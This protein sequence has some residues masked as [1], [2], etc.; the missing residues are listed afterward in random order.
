MGLRSKILLLLFSVLLSIAPLSAQLVA[1]FDP[2]NFSGN[3]SNSGCSP[4]IVF[5]SDSST[6]NGSPV[7]YR[8]IANGDPFNS[9]QWF[10]GLGLGT[11]STLYRPS[12]VYTNAGTYTARLIVTNDGINYDT[13]T[14]QITVF[15]QPVVGFYANV[16]SGCNPLTV[17]LCDTSSGS[18]GWVWDDGIGNL[19][20]DSCIVVTYNIG[21]NGQN[22]FSVTLIAE[23]QYGC[24]RSLTKNNYICIDRPPQ[25]NFGADQTVLC[26]S[27]FTV[28]F[29]DSSMSTNGLSYNWNFGAGQGGS[30]Q[31]NPSHTY[32]DTT[33]SYTVQ[34]TVTDSA[35]GT[36]STRSR[37]SYIRTSNVSA[38]FTAS[39]DTICAGESVSF[40]SNIIGTYTGVRWDFGPPGATSTQLNPTRVYNTP[41]L[42][43]V[44]LTVNGSYGC[45]HDTT[46]PDMIYVRPLPT[47][48][49]NG[50][51]TSSCQ[52]PFDVTFTPVTGP[53]VVSWQWYFQHPNPNIT[54]S[55]FS[56]TYT[57]NN[58]G[59]YNVRLVVTDIYGCTNT[60][61]KNN[62]IQI[63]PTTVDFSMDTSE[64]CAPL[65]VD[66]TDNSSSFEP[67]ISWSWD[68][69]DGMTSAIRNT[70]HTYNNVGVYSACLTI[71]TQSG[72]V[73]TR[74]YDVRVGSSATAAFT[75]STLSTCVDVPVSFVNNSS[76]QIDEYDW[77]FG[78]GSSGSSSNTPQPYPYETAG[79]YTVELTVGYNGC[80]S[81]TS[82]D[83]E[84]I[85]P[86]ADFTYQ[87]NCQTRGNLEF[88]NTSQGGDLFEWDFGDGSPTVN[89]ENP[90]HVYA[91]TGS[92]DVTLTVT[93]TTNG[94]V[95]EQTETLVVSVLNADFT[96]S[97]TSGCAP[98]RIFF[99][100]TST[101][102]QISYRWNFGDPGSGT[103]G[104]LLAN[105]EH[106]YSNPG[107]YTVR[108]IVTD[109]YGC[110]DTM[111]RPQYITISDIVADFTASPLTG[112]IEAATGQSPTV[113][114]TDLSVN[115]GNGPVTW[116]WNF[117]DLNTSTV[118]N[119]SHNYNTAG[120]YDIKLRVRNGDGCVDSMV[121]PQYI[122][123]NQP[124]ANFSIPFNLFCIGQPINFLNTTAGG[125][126]IYHWDFGV[127]GIN[128]DTSRQRDP[129]YAYNDTGFYDVGLWVTDLFGCKDSLIIP[130]AIRI[131]IPDLAFTADDTFR[132][133]PPHIVNFTNFASFDTAQVD[134]VLWNFG[135]N[136]FS[137]VFNPSHIYNRAGQF[138]V[139]LE[140][141]FSN[142]CVDSICVE[143]YVN[144]G[145]AQGNVTI[146]PEFG[147]SPLD[148]CLEANAQG[149][150][151]YFWLFGDGA[152]VQGGDSVCH[153]YATAG[154]FI[155]AVVLVDTANPPCQYVLPYD[156]TLVVDTT[157]TWFTFSIDS[158]CQNEPIQFFDS[159][160]TIANR[161][162]V[163]WDWDFGD[164][165]T[166]TVR[167]PVH[168][169]QGVSGNI[170]V[171]LTTISSLGCFSTV[172]RN[173]FVRN[174]PT[175]DFTVSDSVGCD[176][177]QVVFTDASIPGDAPITS[178]FWNFGDPGTTTDTSTIQNPPPY[179]YAD[180]GTYNTYLIVS[181]AD[182][183]DDTVHLTI[184][185][186]PSP[187]GIAGLDTLAICLYDT[188]QLQGDTGYAS[189]DWSPG[190][191]LSDSTVAQPLATPLDTITY[192]LLTTDIYGCTTL[193]SVTIVV[194]PLPQLSVTPYPD[195][196]IC[197][198]DSVQLV[199]TGTGIGYAWEPVTGLDNP[200]TFNPVARPDSTTDYVVY[201]VDGN[202][203]NRR[204]T[205]TVIVP[206]FNPNFIASRECLGDQTTFID[207]SAS[208]ELPITGY[209]W[210][211]DDDQ[212]PGLDTSIM[213][214]PFYT[215]TD[216][217]RYQVQLVVYNA[218]GCTD[219]I[220]K[221][222]IVDH[223]PAPEA[224]P[225]TS[226]C[227][228]S[229]VQLFSEGGD[230]LYWTPAESLSDAGIYDPIATPLTTTTYTVH[231]T[232]G[233]CPWDMAQTTVTVNA[234]PYLES[235]EPTTILYGSNI[236]LTTVAP[237]FD[238]VYWVPPDSLSC[239][240]CLS[241]V[242]S[243]LVT[244]IYTV[245]II[246]SNGCTNT[247]SVA[248]TVEEKCDEDQIFVGNGFTPNGD[249]V[250]D[251]AFARLLGLKELKYFRIFDRWGKLMF[252]TSNPNEGWDGKNASGEQLN[253]GVYVYVVEAECFSGQKLVK[254]GNVTIIK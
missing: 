12:F 161:P 2:T 102:N 153:T 158:I 222:A 134:S 33:N 150:S 55:Q 14:T 240:T 35:C 30:T 190:I 66:F 97:R 234:T 24:T 44:T 34:L 229:S 169:Y 165:N 251:L 128:S 170:P 94:C 101:G 178:W 114:F 209:H 228:G 215:Y 206:Q 182:G 157:I 17:T 13:T 245:T 176:D 185:V 144:I 232:N 104:S 37:T 10:P 210:E 123:I 236:E 76:G 49:F 5:F 225:D 89:Q 181:S 16:T 19:Y 235:L 36:I 188:I 179:F 4:F 109:S 62:F 155:P 48:D 18:T 166:D 205:T 1:D 70:A 72:C 177:L 53:D 162:I 145:G 59:N 230:T 99:T 52:A 21:S 82:I 65:H 98:A 249:G 238:T 171:T 45:V 113:N 6:F 183:C 154:L 197:R 140:V 243:P 231:M 96:V 40:T 57:Y 196:T 116:N 194:N 111:L 244:T 180:T 126:Y 204:D 87:L 137:T 149:A 248:I 15:P 43:P 27:P 213:R 212:T 175:A 246:D 23:N 148:V 3:V 160:Y 167:N 146:D 61:I 42:W 242:A 130:N 121:R 122:D 47:V 241:P 110:S 174:N 199:A 11:P 217:G 90:T 71:V 29:Y 168:V 115:S 107:V 78:D 221:T 112:C 203:C 68:F 46:I 95:S 192:S 64:G 117:G 91:A 26:D 191:W 88:T 136:S 77:D 80:Y 224:Y 198:G 75:P 81:D 125:P 83:I 118:Q 92:Y 124:N 135:D 218:L 103:N 7:P 141:F 28:Q 237:V 156:D 20:Y 69:G 74:C 223:P 133:C 63:A 58:P 139:C 120:L 86:D 67:I 159:S 54:T 39:V 208:Q 9:H 173:V 50:N 220:V 216:S 138:T 184:N 108:L 142:G 201:T 151:S 22:C 186:Y 100:S 233:V 119:P 51:A 31:Q 129:S 172:T 195:T 207:R 131:S 38:S 85:G 187:N 73:G 226:I 127:P 193:D 79:T 152:S 252:E 227:E 41:G 163:S 84:V 254:T 106:T 202:G 132:Y 8:S 250:N 239:D 93:D 164:G 219:T 143:D 32:P 211:F 189:Y 147:C 200:N 214:N 56:P 105:P 253:S 60:I 25:A 247:R